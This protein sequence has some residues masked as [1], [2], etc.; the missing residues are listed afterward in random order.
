MARLRQSSVGRIPAKTNKLFISVGRRHPVTMQKTSL[1][2]LLM[3]REWALRHQTSE[4]YS[5]AEYTKAKVTV[6]NVIAAAPQVNPTNRLQG[7]T[8]VVNFFAVTQG[9]GGT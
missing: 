1:I 9:V 7:P 5:A 4:Q 3:N 8:C 6:R 2:S